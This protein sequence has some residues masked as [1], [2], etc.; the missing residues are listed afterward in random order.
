MATLTIRQLEE[1][2]KVQLRIRAAEKGHSMEEEV[3]Q[4]LRQTVLQTPP[5][6]GFGTAAAQHFAPCATD[7][8][9]PERQLPRPPVSF[10]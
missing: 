7:L 1:T 6:P 9:I 2:L 8:P 10:D 5:K 3:R 4:I